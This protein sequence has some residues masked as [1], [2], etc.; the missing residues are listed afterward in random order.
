MVDGNCLDLYQL[1]QGSPHG[2]VNL[3]DRCNYPKRERQTQQHQVG[4][5]PLE[6]GDRDTDSLL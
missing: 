6:D 1:L 3:E 4:G 5:G 2:G